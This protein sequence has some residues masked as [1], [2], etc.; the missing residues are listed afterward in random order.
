MTTDS[1]LN[2][3]NSM[4]LN[5]KSKRLVYSLRHDH[6][7]QFDV[8]GWRE[9]SDLIDNHRFTYEDLCDIVK[10]NNKQ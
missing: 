1:I 7:Y 3:E 2:I 10:T 8:N 9:V 5:N 4:N 6:K